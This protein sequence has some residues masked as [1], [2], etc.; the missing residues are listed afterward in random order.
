[1]RGVVHIV[2]KWYCTI[3]QI[4]GVE[5]SV[6]QQ[7]SARWWWCGEVHDAITTVLRI[8]IDKENSC[9]LRC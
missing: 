9:K 2:A 1:M 5:A 6:G 3:L 7:S 8:A 4:L